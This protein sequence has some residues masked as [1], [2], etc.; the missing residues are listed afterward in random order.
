MQNL[1]RI[2]FSTMLAI[3]ISYYFVKPQIRTYTKT[4]KIPES[5]FDRILSL[6]ENVNERMARNI[7]IGFLICVPVFIEVTALFILTRLFGEGNSGLYNNLFCWGCV[8][9]EMIFLLSFHFY[10]AMTSPPTKD[11]SEK[12]FN[13]K[14]WGDGVC[15]IRNI[16]IAKKSSSSLF[17]CKLHSWIALYVMALIST[18]IQAK[19]NGFIRPLLLTG[20]LTSATGAFLVLCSSNNDNEVNR[21]TTM[22]RAVLCN[23]LRDLIVDIGDEVVEDEMLKL[24]ILRWIVNYWDDNKP[25]ASVQKSTS[26]HVQSTRDT[27]QIKSLKGNSLNTHDTKASPIGWDELA[28]MLSITTDQMCQESYRSDP[29]DTC[30][31]RDNS[32]FNF[33]QFI[34]TFSSNERAK[35]ALASYRKAIEDI[36]P[37]RLTASLLSLAYRCP[38][39]LCSIY[40]LLFLPYDATRCIPPLIPLIILEVARIS[41]WLNSCA[42]CYEEMEGDSN[43]DWPLSL[44]PTQMS[45]MEILLSPD[46]FSKNYPGP[47]LQ[48]WSNIQMSV[49]ALESGLVAMKCAHTVQLATDVVLAVVSLA[50]L[51]A[52]IHSNGIHSSFGAILTKF[53]QIYANRQNPNQGKTGTFA[54][55]ALTLATSFQKLMKNSSDLMEEYEII[56]NNKV[57]ARILSFFQK[58][59]ETPHPDPSSDVGT[60]VEKEKEIEK[61]RES[62]IFNEDESTTAEP[63]C[64]TTVT[65]ECPTIGFDDLEFEGEDQQGDGD[66]ESVHSWTEIKEGNCQNAD[67]EKEAHESTTFSSNQSGSY[68][69]HSSVRIQNDN[70]ALKW[71]AAAAA[72]TGT[73]IGA[74]ALVDNKPKRDETNK[75][76]RQRSTVTIERLDEDEHK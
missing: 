37:S 25:N 48:V 36:P 53:V 68:P 45:S 52:E 40:L 55:T 9:M 5:A 72:I 8:V 27:N 39:V 2:L 67:S 71:I 56:P 38:A 35:P 23:T 64:S 76:R 14:E 4:F 74:I 46:T 12:N 69:R 21:E 1:H 20:P 26:I 28:T 43:Q 44:F 17:E 29:I 41:K 65:G 75:A 33:K 42:L 50:N 49:Q 32:F 47:L 66:N 13:W 6:L 16:T 10:N 59:V 19:M 7:T 54:H 58:R 51:S 70:Q 34:A 3:V 57:L 22:L 73:V 15:N 62:H 60:V 63:T 30:K 31:R 11:K 24:T 18:I 61:E